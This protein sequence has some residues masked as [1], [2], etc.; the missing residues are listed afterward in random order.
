M[1]NNSLILETND[2]DG[3]QT[4]GMIHVVNENNEIQ[5]TCRTLE[6]PWKDNQKYISCIPAGVYKVIKHK[7]PKFKNCFWIQDV[8]DRSEILIHKGNYHTDIL[9][10]VLVGSDLALV[11]ND[12]LLDV[13]D[14]IKTI[15]RLN[16]LLPKEFEI[17]IFRT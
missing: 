5:L 15:A 16:E 4:L 6:L 13:K 11:N 2:D 14:S 10:C 9:G 12:K 7:S 17:K 3:V 1:K 8:P